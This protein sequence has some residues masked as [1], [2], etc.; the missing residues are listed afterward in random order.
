MT[1]GAT[2]DAQARARAAAN[3]GFLVEKDQS[4]CQTVTTGV[5][6]SAT[7][8]LLSIQATLAFLLLLASSQCH[9]PCMALATDYRSP[10]KPFKLGSMEDDQVVLPKSG[11]QAQVISCVPTSKMK[12]TDKPPIV[13]LHGSFHGA[14]CWAE[15]YI[16]YFVEKGFPCIALSWRGTGGTPA[17]DGVKKVKILEHCDDL[18][19]LLDAIPSIIGK[20]YQGQK[21]ILV[22]HSMGGIYVMKYLEEAWNRGTSPIDMFSGIASFCSTPPSG[23]GKSTM[24]VL[25]RSLRDAYRITVGFVFKKVN[26]D[27]TTCRLCFFGGEPKVLNDGTIDDL[28]VSDEDVARYQTYFE[29][30]SQAVL[31]VSDLSRRLPS[32][33][34]DAQGRA[35]FVKDLPPCLVVGASDDFI[36]DH[37]GNEETARYY[38]L[39]K[40]KYVDSPHDIML[41]R[42]WQ[43][44][45]DIL[46]EWIEKDVLEFNLKK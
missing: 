21:P 18:Q 17:G 20:G 35:P 30:D 25:G 43:N 10:Q 46:H 40:P 15:N 27:A 28:G 13:F 3:A 23:N 14:W 36:V 24:R 8:R 5:A 16:P 29:R 38:G 41:T 32:K 9:H 37:V 12:K 33:L 1:T 39:D 22:S 19:G 2:V 34:V 11:I 26:T 7:M 45:A 4:S 31:D 42:K 6:K 44:G